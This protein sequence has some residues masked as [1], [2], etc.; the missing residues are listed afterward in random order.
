MPPDFVDSDEELSQTSCASFWGPFR[1]LF[2]GHSLR[3]AA[4]SAYFPTI[5]IFIWRVVFALFM[6][7]TF[8]VYT[9]NGQYTFQFYSIWCHL[10]ISI[11]FIASSLASA[12]YLSSKQPRNR[13]CSFFAFVV[14]LLFQVFATAALFLDL[15]FW[16]LLFD[17]DTKPDI[18]TLAQHAFNL[19]FVL[20]DILLSVRMQ[21]KLIYGVVF[22]LYT[23]S[24]LVFAWIRFAITDD[25]MYN[26]L[27]YQRQAA[28]TT[29]AYYL[30]IF[31][32]AAVAAI[33]VILLSRISRCACS[34]SRRADAS[35]DDE[36]ADKI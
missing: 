3:E 10:G 29:V 32:W 9:I 22:I 35:V 31:V 16:A 5:V 6:S 13:N 4:T 28:G 24:F 8:L 19:V 18:A 1:P 11:A 2:G 14:V 23:I 25:W 26:F 17:F 30:G 33:I 27:D 7:T 36:V 15:V 12:L 34:K 21:F 20:L